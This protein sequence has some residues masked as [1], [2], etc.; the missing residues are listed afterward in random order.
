MMVRGHH[1]NIMLG[2]YNM[3]EQSIKNEKAKPLVVYKV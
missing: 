3:N 1:A 2:N